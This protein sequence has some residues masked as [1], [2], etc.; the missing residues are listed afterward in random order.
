MQVQVQV[1]RI[2]IGI[3]KK[4]IQCSHYVPYLYLYISYMPISLPMFKKCWKPE[5]VRYQ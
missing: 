2:D 4:Q 5:K 1:E 3:K